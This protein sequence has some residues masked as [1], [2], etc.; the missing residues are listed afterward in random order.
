MN[1]QRRGQMM[2][3]HCRNCG[4]KVDTFAV[5]NY[6]YGSPVR[7]CPECKTEYVN[8]A[9]HEIEVDG[10][11]PD[12]FNM[13]LIFAGLF[14]GV[15]FFVIG[16]VIHYFEVTTQ[17]YYHLVPIAIM[18]ISAIVVF[19]ALGNILFIKTG[20]KD[21]WTESKRSQSA[22]RMSNPDYALKLKEF[23]YN[24]PEKY[25]PQEYTENNKSHI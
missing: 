10:I 4:R 19:Y 15:A 7:T 12:A 25:L 20:I 13:R 11:A 5:G 6:R 1:N 18:I 21:R 16:A 22:E 24:V 9:V 8:P 14:M 2:E 23:G 3:I 17:N